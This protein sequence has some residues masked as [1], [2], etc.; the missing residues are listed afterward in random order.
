[1]AYPVYHERQRALWC[2]LHSV[3]NA[4][5]YSCF[6]PEQALHEAQQGLQRELKWAKVNRAEFDWSLG[7]GFGNLDVSVIRDLL[8]K[9]GH[10]T[11]FVRTFGQG[12]RLV[13]H[14]TRDT[15][16]RAFICHVRNS[17]Y[18][19]LTQYQGKWFCHDSEEP[20]PSAV[21]AGDIV[22]RLFPALCEGN[23]GRFGRRLL[24]FTPIDP[25]LQK[26]A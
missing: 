9:T 21:S 7:N 4:L 15:R 20:A 22:F 6:T 24:F 23:R 19:A 17:H 26:I 14:H 8:E 2:A 18:I 11:F 10:A 12:L 5:L 3:N 16:R 1:M 13:T 25:L